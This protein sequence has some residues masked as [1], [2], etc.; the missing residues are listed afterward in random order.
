MEPNIS[1]IGFMGCA[2]Q[3][4]VTCAVL[5]EVGEGSFCRRYRRLLLS[6]RVNIGLPR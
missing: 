3:T 6:G 5:T 4:F 1:F 2:V